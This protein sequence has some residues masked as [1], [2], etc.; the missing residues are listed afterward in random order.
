MSNTSSPKLL[1]ENWRQIAQDQNHDKEELK[2]WHHLI[3]RFDQALAEVTASILK[4]AA[5]AEAL[6]QAYADIPAS[7]HPTLR[8]VQTGGLVAA[9]RWAAIFQ[10][11][12]MLKANIALAEQAVRSL[13]AVEAPCSAIASAFFEAEFFSDC[14]R[15]TGK[16]PSQSEEGP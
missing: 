15:P 16:Q 9:K 3:D 8:L 14:R 7:S 11:S 10:C 13:M 4:L 1:P 12:L 6:A 2:Q 5:K